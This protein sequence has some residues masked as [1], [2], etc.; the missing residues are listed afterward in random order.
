M[1]QVSLGSLVPGGVVQVSVEQGYIV[2]CMDCGSVVQVCVV[3]GG[4]VLVGMDC[5]SVCRFAL[6][7]V[8]WCRLAWCLVV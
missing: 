7:L 8:V 4:V 6:C 1:V 2:W 3:S 5:G